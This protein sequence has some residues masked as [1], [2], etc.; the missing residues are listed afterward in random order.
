MDQS[1]VWRIL[2]I[3]CAWWVLTV[4][5]LASIVVNFVQLCVLA[6]V[7]LPPKIRLSVNQQL[8]NV[9]WELFPFLLEGFG[10][11][12][13]RFTGETLRDTEQAIMLGNHA[14]GMDFT[15]GVSVMHRA[16]KVGTGRLMT[17]MKKSLQWVPGLG[18][19]H[20]LQGS[21]FLARNWEKDHAMI[22][23]KLLDM[24]K[25]SFPRPF[26]VGIYP[27]G[28]RITPE[29]KEASLKFAASR[30]LP[31]LHN[32]LLPRTKGFI[33][34]VKSLP[35]CI[36]AVYDLTIAFEGSPV[37]FVHALRSGR[38][39]T[40]CIHIHIT[41]VSFASIPKEN[42]K[43]L[44]DWLVNKFVEKDQLLGHYK[45]WGCFPGTYNPAMHGNMQRLITIFGVM[46]VLSVSLLSQISFALAFIGLFLTVCVILH[47][48]SHGPHD[49]QRSNEDEPL[50]LQPPTIATKST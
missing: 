38:F 25:G 8:A 48:R 33:F 12:P 27:E 44:N 45:E 21:L 19:T 23:H 7:F 9:W 20:Y 50:I 4:I 35:S 49:M 1:V 3:P 41:R 42:E 32:V 15:S 14:A 10:H 22:S 18:F 43:D 37:S 28:T 34:V 13:I 47:V 31:Q 17:M 16:P 30:G 6:F 46:A 26:W 36:D 5:L 29:K 39:R 11:I 40:S 2:L 24:E